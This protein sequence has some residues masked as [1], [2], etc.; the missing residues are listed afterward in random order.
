[1][2]YYAKLGKCLDEEWLIDEIQDDWFRISNPINGYFVR[3]G[4]DAKREWDDDFS[5]QDGIRRG[6]II[7]KAQIT[8]RDGTS[9][10]EPLTDSLLSKA[11]KRMPDPR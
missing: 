7:L 5:R 11:M 3:V 1:M 9:I 4:H 2:V 6:I 8:L 10:V